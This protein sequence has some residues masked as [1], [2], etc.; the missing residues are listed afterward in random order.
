MAIGFMA[1]DAGVIEG[2]VLVFLVLV[3]TW[4]L[5]DIIRSR[6]VDAERRAEALERSMREREDRVRTAAA[7]ERR[8]VAR[9]LHDV[10]A[11]AVSV[12]V[13]QAGAARK[14]LRTN[15]D[16]AKE[17]ML[18]VESTV[19]RRWWSCVAS[20]VLWATTTRPPGSPR[21]PASPS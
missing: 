4:L 6:R 7:E 8:H 13:I 11:H 18:A 17:S 12:M 3:P 1:Q 15:P 5:G 9:E 10:V 20:W 2:L 21:S 16:Q 14:V 19:A